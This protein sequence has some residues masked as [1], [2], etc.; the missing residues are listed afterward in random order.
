MDHMNVM[1]EHY[2]N[3]GIKEWY[4]L[5]LLGLNRLLYCVEP[6]PKEWTDL[7]P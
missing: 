5:S 7:S 6:P 4:G 3:I 1:I 2:I